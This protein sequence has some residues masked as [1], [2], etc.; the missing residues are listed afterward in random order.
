LESRK[1]FLKL[2]TVPCVVVLLAMAQAVRSAET[3]DRKTI[4]R[5]TTGFF[6]EASESV[7][8]VVERVFADLGEPNGYIAGNEA[9]GAVVVGARYGDGMLRL[10]N[11]AQRQVH[12]TG[13]SIGFDAGG[14]VSKTFVLVY[15][16]PNVDALFKRFPAVDGSIY[17]VGGVSAN[18]HQRDDIVLV[19]IRLGAGLRSGVN[20]GYMRYTK[21]KTWNPF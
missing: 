2:L 9:S 20:I 10:K 12:W 1:L 15:N 3:Y 8:K 11:G 18:Y 19:P 17:L 13:P 6:G 21:K 7:A 5:E 14:N 16:L 4:L